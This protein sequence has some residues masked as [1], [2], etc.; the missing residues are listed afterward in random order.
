[1]LVALVLVVAPS[2]KL[3]LRLVMVPVELSVKVTVNGTTPLVGVA[4]N[5]ATGTTAPVPTTMFVDVPPLAV[6]KIAVLVKSP[7]LDGAN[8][9][10]TLVEPPATMS[11]ELPDMMVNGPAVTVAMPF[12]IM[13]PPL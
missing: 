6:V 10:T 2:P 3:Q 8:C 1:M 7:S 5:T 4:L 11:N 12:V 13:V 9:M